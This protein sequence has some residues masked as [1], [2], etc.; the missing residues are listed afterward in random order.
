MVADLYRGLL[1]YDILYSGAVVIYI[2]VE[3]WFLYDNMNIVA[4]IDTR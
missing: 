4:N 2:Y 1:L 3:R